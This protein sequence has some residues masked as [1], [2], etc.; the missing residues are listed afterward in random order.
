MLVV[1]WKHNNLAG[2]QAE[3]DGSAGE[4]CAGERLNKKS[5]LSSRVKVEV[6]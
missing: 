4:P 3:M 6:Q 5:G 2:R 1:L